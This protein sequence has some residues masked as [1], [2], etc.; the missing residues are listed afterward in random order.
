MDAKYYKLLTNDTK[1]LVVEIE[2]AIDKDIEIKI[3]SKPQDTLACNVDGVCPVI[4][5]PKAD[6]FPES[7]VV[8]ELIHI[9]RF[10][11]E[12]VPSLSVMEEYWS[13][14]IEQAFLA[15]DNDLEH[16]CVI[17]EEIRRKPD[18]FQRWQGEISK[19]IDVIEKSIQYNEDDKKNF[20]VR[21]LL[22]LEIAVVDKSLANRVRQLLK[23]K[24]KDDLEEFIFQIK[25]N[26][27]SKEV[28]CKLFVDQLDLWKHSPC[29]EYKASNG[30]V[31]QKPL[32][33]KR[34]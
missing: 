13:H 33:R 26:I 3:V 7:S 31:I 22:I 34:H 8:H 29:L 19:K 4:I 27:R 28:V 14:K 20:L 11:V 25:Q 10:L 9:R 32:C 15:I 1:N 12:R 23:R 2:S 30:S 21:L 6:F 18:R 5:L 24:I 16:L 17:P